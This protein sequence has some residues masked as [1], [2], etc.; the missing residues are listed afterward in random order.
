MDPRS[1]RPRPATRRPGP[2]RP[3]HPDRPHDVVVLGATGFAGRLT[4][5]Y[6]AR[7]APEG[8]RWALAGRSPEKLA[9][10]R[11]ELAAIDPACADLPLLR[12]D[13][14]DERSLRELAERSRVIATTVGPYVL[15]G[16]GLVAACAASGTDYL[17]LT[18]EPEFVD[19]SYVRHHATA[20]DTGARLVHAAGFDSVP[21]DL[22][23]W[24]TV[25]RLPE[26]AAIR[27]SGYVRA[28]A[29]FSGGT[30]HS[31]VTAVSRPR[32]NVTAARARREREPRDA[33]GRH[34]RARLGVPHRAPF[35]GWA[36]PLPTL[37]PQIVARSARA[38][39]RYGPDFT[40]SHYVALP[41]LRT[42]VGGMAGVGAI[43]VA[44]QL[45]PARRA[46]LSKVPA[47]NGPSAERR[48][49]SWF[50]V[51]FVGEG[52]GEQARTR[53]SGG[54]PGY[55][56]TAKMLAESA[57]CLAF[58]DLPAT[59]GQV[60]TATAMGGALV[61][62]LRDAGLAFEVLDD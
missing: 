22:G 17:D 16:D 3:R 11:D 60:T 62:R 34:V 39:A 33:S 24:F 37:D 61:D 29:T 32:Q 52:G 23:A 21:H 15:H 44:A 27:L 40:Y 6:L 28:S 2:D 50:S 47:G 45:P 26:G 57:L 53:V 20:A 55:D 25:R 48:A 18:G 19:V 10:V 54:D 9:R 35:G 51:T 38:D 58:D 12:A 59:S 5:E 43:T 14:T 13:V 46:M 4:A 41:H 31:L 1:D 8:C 42:A 7:H 30:F 56:E 49:R 36:V